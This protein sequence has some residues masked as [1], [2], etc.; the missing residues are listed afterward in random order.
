MMTEVVVSMAA[1]SWPESWRPK[2]FGPTAQDLFVWR[3]LTFPLY[4]IPFWWFAGIGVDAA[5]S[6]RRPHWSILLIGTLLVALF[7]LIAIAVTFGVDADDHKDMAFV[8][9]GFAIWIPLLSAFPIAWI[10]R[11][12]A[13]RNQKKSLLVPHS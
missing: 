3:G 4:C 10:R 5:M 1:G 9:F 6:R 7:L 12:I 2:S 11:W 8:F 13:W